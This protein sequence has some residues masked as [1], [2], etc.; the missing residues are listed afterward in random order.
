MLLLIGVYA[1]GQSVQ[2]A[3]QTTISTPGL[4]LGSVAVADFNHDGIPDL[5]IPLDNAYYADAVALGKGAGRFGPWRYSA[6]PANSAIVAVGDFNGDGN[7][8]TVSTDALSNTVSTGLGLGDGTFCCYHYFDTA[9]P[10]WSTFS[11]AYGILVADVNGDNIPDLLILNY[12]NTDALSNGVFVSLGN[13]DGT[14]QPYKR[15]STRGTG[16]TQFVMGDFNGDGIADIAVA[17]SGSATFGTDN[18]AILLGNGDGSF[19]SAM[20]SKPVDIASA[21]A[22]GDFNGDG[23][24]DLAVGSS[25]FNQLSVI[26][27]RGDGTFS[28]PNGLISQHGIGVADVKVAD[29]NGDGKMDLAVLGAQCTGCYPEAV[30]ILLG[31]GDGTFQAPVR[32][33]VPFGG[34]NMAI[35]DLNGDGKPDIIVINSHNSTLNILLNTTP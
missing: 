24:L 2:F 13:G 15:Y 12:G 3:P 7:I 33:D 8:D 4:Y 14:F 18:L 20:L 9:I 5:L 26:L 32:F 28:N 21:V 6:A 31:N 17:D 30:S 35:A 10:P 16:A 29:F 11:L 22:A 1:F 19:Q 23:I 25:R 27:G 34:Y